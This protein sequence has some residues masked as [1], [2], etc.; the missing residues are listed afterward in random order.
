MAGENVTSSKVASVDT[1]AQARQRSSISFPYVDLGAAFNLALAIHSHVGHGSCTEDQ[2]AA[3]TDQSARSSGFREQIRAAKMASLVEGE[4]GNLHLVDYGQ[5][6]AD[7]DKARNAKARAFLSVPLFKAVY[8][9]YRGTVLPPAAA[10]ERDMVGLGVSEKQKDRARQVLERSADLS[11]F[12]ESGKT[13][14]VMPALAQ[15]SGGGAGREIVRDKGGSGGQGDSRTGTGGSGAGSGSGNGSGGQNDPLINALIQ[16]L[17]SGGNWPVDDR[18]NWLKMLVMGF[19]VAYGAEAEIE[20]KK[21][22][23]AN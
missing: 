9:K 14:L 11:G 20:I 7:P 10:L 13:K 15:G 21:K 6:L 12:F 4:N 17:P 23:A 5:W 3:W 19:Q 1:D 18:I 16:K 2:L 8:E 22:E